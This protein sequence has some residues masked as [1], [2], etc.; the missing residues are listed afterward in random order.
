MRALRIL[1][2]AATLAAATAA[3]AVDGVLEINQT[4]AVNTGCFTGDTAGFPVTITTSGSYRLTGNLSVSDP[5]TNGIDVTSENVT[6]DFNS[7]GLDGPGSGSGRGVNAADPST[8]L[9]DGFVRAFGGEGISLSSGLIERMFVS[10]N[11]GTG[12]DVSG[13]AVV[14]DS[15]LLYNGGNGI[16]FGPNSGYADCRFEGNSGSAVSGGRPLG[17]NLC[18]DPTCF[19]TSYRRYYLTTSF[20]PADQALTACAAGFHMASLW[21]IRDTSN[22]TYDV[23][24]G[25]SWAVSDSGSGPP[26]AFGWIRTGGSSASSP[27]P[28]D[29]NCHSWT[30]ATGDDWGTAVALESDWDTNPGDVVSPWSAGVRPC[31]DGAWVWCVQD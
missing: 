26:T 5:G 1:A 11:G 24:L 21:E 16:V 13:G 28:G 22:L 17:D 3:Q 4:C 9:R 27:V 14:R 18:D 15:H 10:V 8:K 12:I 6:I 30:S 7:F 29:A 31:D 19:S 2:A 20:L 25:W 23:D